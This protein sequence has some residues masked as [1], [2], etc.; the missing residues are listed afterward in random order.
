MWEYRIENLT[1]IKTPDGTPAEEEVALLER[2]GEDDWELV[3]V[4]AVNWEGNT[5][6]CAYYFK[7][8]RRKATP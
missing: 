4:V 7:R 8:H 3:S 6:W 1:L 5:S 2:V